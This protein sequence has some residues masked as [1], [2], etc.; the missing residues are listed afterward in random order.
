[1]A[2]V[3]WAGIFFASKESVS[4]SPAKQRSF[5]LLCRREKY[6]F[7]K[8]IPLIESVPIFIESVPILIESVPILI[9]S[10]PIFIQK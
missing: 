9:E 2:R 7:C 1:M 10:V 6:L 3:M 4:H 8:G 5:F